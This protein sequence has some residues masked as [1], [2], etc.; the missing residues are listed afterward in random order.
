MIESKIARKYAT[1]LF[2]TAKRT[3]QVEIISRDL[4][5][6]SDLLNKNLPLKHFL[7]SP[8][9]LEK[10]KKEL[11]HSA[12]KT[13][14]SPALFSFLMLVVEKHR[15]GYILSMA[16]EFQRLVKEDQ[17]IVEVRLITA[18]PAD[19]DLV[20]Q[21]R[22]ELEKSSGKKV[23]IKLE[24]DAHLIGGIVVIFGDKIIDRSI[25]YQLN[26]LKEQMVSLKVY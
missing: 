17:G 15:I 24:T 18:H 16:E 11:L 7:E 1:A 22:Q 26:Q 21:I 12:F 14:V 25:R 10:K 13:S 8:Q 4:L 2:H 3:K 19:R 5:A 23:E 6:L 9:V 20:E